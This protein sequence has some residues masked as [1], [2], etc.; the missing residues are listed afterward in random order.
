MKSGSGHEPQSDSYTSEVHGGLCNPRTSTNCY[1]GGV[2]PIPNCTN[3]L[4]NM[5]GH[6]CWKGSWMKFEGSPWLV[7]MLTTNF[8][9]L[10][11]LTAQNWSLFPPSAY[12]IQE[13]ILQTPVYSARWPRQW[14]SFLSYTYVA[15]R[16][17]W[18]EGS[19][20]NNA[21]WLPGKVPL[22]NCSLI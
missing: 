9:R 14:Q 2:V 4:G 6:V 21:G 5:G 3:V 20:R 22:C 1:F 12:P 15:F 8:H 19:K 10:L 13:V 7:Q 11:S 16:V 18:W 17:I